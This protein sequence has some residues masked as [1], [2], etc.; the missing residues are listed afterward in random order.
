YWRDASEV[1]DVE[2]EAAFADFCQWMREQGITWTSHA[3]ADGAEARTV[4]SEGDGEQVET[5]GPLTE[6]TDVI[7]GLFVLDVA[8]KALAMEAARRC[9]K[10]DGGGVELRE[11]VDS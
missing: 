1:R 2:E 9:P 7:A 3:L 10:V 6:I 11:I 5:V 8:S 4:R